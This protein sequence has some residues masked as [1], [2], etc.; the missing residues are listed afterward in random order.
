MLQSEGVVLSS[1][2]K[3]Q[4][5]PVLLTLTE[6]E[7]SITIPMVQSARLKENQYVSYYQRLRPVISVPRR[8]A[9]DVP[10]LRVWKRGRLETAGSV[11]PVSQPSVLSRPVLSVPHELSARSTGG[12]L[13][14]G[15]C[16][17]HARTHARTHTH[18]HPHTRT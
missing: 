8:R 11:T 13:P 2:L 3:T 14:H 17:S 18:T 4:R 12:A 6:T 9:A 5:V 15:S 16:F 7:S 1:T 10:Q